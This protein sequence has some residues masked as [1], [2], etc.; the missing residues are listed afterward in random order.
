MF[1]KCLLERQL[2]AGLKFTTATYSPSTNAISERSFSALGR[3]NCLRSSMTQERSTRC[4]GQPRRWSSSTKQK[5]VNPQVWIQNESIHCDPPQSS[6][7]FL[8]TASSIGYSQPVQQSL[9]SESEQTHAN[10]ESLSVGRQLTPV[11]VWFSQLKRWIL[12]LKTK[13]WWSKL[14]IT[15]NDHPKISVCL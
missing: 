8:F 3:V 14:Y 4:K 11:Y 9:L 1:R 13:V 7:N 10:S 5:E 6:W 12:Q 2:I 15:L